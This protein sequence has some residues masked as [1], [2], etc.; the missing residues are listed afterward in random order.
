MLFVGRFGGWWRGSWVAFGL[1]L[2]HLGKVL[3]GLGGLGIDSGSIFGAFLEHVGS[4]WGRFLKLKI[5]RVT[6][7]QI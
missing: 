6:K 3:G 1:H 7:I 2:G 5:F 4:T